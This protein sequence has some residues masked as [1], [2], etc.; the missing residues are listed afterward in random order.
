M[1]RY[2]FIH[3]NG[4]VTRKTLTR[5]KATKYGENTKSVKLYGLSTKVVVPKK[6]SK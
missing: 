5:S 3:K 4:K 2:V 1:P 6:R